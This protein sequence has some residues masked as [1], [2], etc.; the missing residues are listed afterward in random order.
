MAS[1]SYTIKKT[2]TGIQI[3]FHEIEPKT[4]S[5]PTTTTSMESFTRRQ[6]FFDRQDTVIC[7]E[8]EPGHLTSSGNGLMNAIL[9]A[10]SKHTPLRLRPDDVWIALIISFATF[11]IN[12]A[13]QMRRVF[14]DHE[15]K[16]K[17]EIELS[18][19][20]TTL[21]DWKQIIDTLS[22][23]TDEHIK[24]DILE[25]LT[26]QFSTTTELDRRI[27]KVCL[28]AAMKDFFSYPGCM[29]CGIRQLQLEGGV[30]DW[31]LLR[32]KATRFG[33]FAVEE[34][35]SWSQLLLPVLDQFISLYQNPDQVDVDFWRRICTSEPLGSSGE[36][37][38][39]GWFTVFCPF[40]SK[41]SQM[42]RPIDMVKKDGIYAYK[43]SDFVTASADLPFTLHNGSTT[44][45]YVFCVA[46]PFISYID[47]VVCVNGGWSVIQKILKI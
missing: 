33:T 42:L 29:A 44:T 31:I 35:D 4:F 6:D 25:W 21:E 23:K 11:V 9:E 41:G 13:E 5:Q 8:G 47:G 37:K 20:P 2:A 22:A 12:H 24:G 27:A 14:V 40:T 39:T 34:L 15:D 30:D 43:Y 10:Y 46:A 38:Y 45:N 19:P 16:K 28:L 18:D 17:I 1:N 7:T 36:E 26:P 3:T 32:D